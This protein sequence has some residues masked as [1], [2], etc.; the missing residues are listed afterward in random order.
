MSQDDFLENVAHACDGAKIKTLCNPMPQ[1]SYTVLIR[2]SN[3]QVGECETER[4]HEG[5]RHDPEI[6]VKMKIELIKGLHNASK[7]LTH[8]LDFVP[9]GL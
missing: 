5:T 6:S 9:E 2:Q 1:G 8:R 4:M 7:F 3:V